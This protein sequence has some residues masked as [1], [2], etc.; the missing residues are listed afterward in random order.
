MQIHCLR[1]KQVTD[2]VGVVNDTDKRGMSRVKG[3]CQV[4]GTMKYKYVKSGG[5][6]DIH[7]AIGKL[8]RPKGGFTLPGILIL[9]SEES[10]RR[11]DRH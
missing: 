8:P 4:C 9:Q 7:K 11:V 6:L 2:T 1:C 5:S 3:N 10:I